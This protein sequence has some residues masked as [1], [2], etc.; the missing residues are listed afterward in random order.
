MACAHFC[1][2]LLCAPTCLHARLLRACLC[3][4]PEFLRAIIASCVMLHRIYA[5]VVGLCFSICFF[6]FVLLLLVV[7]FLF[8]LYVRARVLACSPACVGIS[9]S[10]AFCF[11]CVTLHCVHA[12]VIVLLFMFLLAF[13]LFLFVCCRLFLLVV[14]TVFLL[15][16]AFVGCVAFVWWLLF[17]FVAFFFCLAC[18]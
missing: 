18:V 9:D 12:C 10:T 14:A 8:Y 6:S 2:I 17:V 11:A 16:C 1:R 3:G 7:L 4:S 15:L 5:C 13:V